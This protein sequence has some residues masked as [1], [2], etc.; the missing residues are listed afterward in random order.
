MQK[1][2]SGRRQLLVVSWGGEGGGEWLRSHGTRETCAAAASSRIS[3][4]WDLAA[5]AGEGRRGVGGMG[6]TSY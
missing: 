1:A 5:G 4:D 3:I 6:G 2:G